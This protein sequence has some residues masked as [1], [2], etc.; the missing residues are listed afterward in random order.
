[1]S[2]D[3][4]ITGFIIGIV[5]VGLVLY[6]IVEAII[7]ILPVL[8]F[9]AVVIIVSI[10]MFSNKGNSNHSVSTGDLGL[11][12]RPE[13]NDVC[14]YCGTVNPSRCCSCN[15]CLNCNY[16]SYPYCNNCV[17]FDD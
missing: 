11:P 17:D 8:A 5:L 4:D 15:N 6:Y 1:M 7:F 3:N 10:I 9:I 12:P 13:P 2:N 16:G 14:E